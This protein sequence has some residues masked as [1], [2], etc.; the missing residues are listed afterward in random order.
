MVSRRGVLAAGAAALLPAGLKA[1]D[2]G[3]E[4]RFSELVAGAPLPAEY[5]VFGFDGVP[6]TQ[7]TA[8]VDEGRVVLR[9]RA[10]ASM[11]AVIRTVRVP[12]AP[13]PEL[14]WRWKVLQ[15][16]EH[17][18]LATRTGDDF[19]ARLYVAF[20]LGLG[21]LP[22]ATRVGVWLAR[23]AYGDDVPAAALC[24]VWANR[25]K[26][27]TVATSAF[28][29]RVRMIVVDGGTAGLGEW[30]AYRRDVVAD[31]ERA[32]GAPAPA[33]IGVAVASDAD[34]TRGRAEAYFGDVRF[35]SRPPA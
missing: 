3:R 28:T 16:P 13:R 15:V 34:N 14:E 20:D 31:Y 23:L 27:G 33:I 19:A 32:F 8:V 9:A 2:E 7:Y 24:Y 10:E 35:R 17:G 21:E 30:R 6:R 4:M 25:A 22:L 18:D 5:R 29:E 1:Q 26:V 11:S 12:A